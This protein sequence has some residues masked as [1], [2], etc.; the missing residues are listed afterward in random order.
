MN[1]SSDGATVIRRRF[2]QMFVRPGLG[3]RGP[4]KRI[5]RPTAI[6]ISRWMTSEFDA[7]RAVDLAAGLIGVKAA[8]GLIKSRL[9][10]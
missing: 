6:S 10:P 4:A 2:A 9:A 8:V 7:D 3:W 1:G 5:G